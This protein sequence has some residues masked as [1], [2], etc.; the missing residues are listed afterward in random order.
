MMHNSNEPTSEN[1]W[2]WGSMSPSCDGGLEHMSNQFTF[3]GFPDECHKFEQ[4]HPIWNEI[5]GNLVKAMNLAFVRVEVM[6]GSAD[7][8][9]YFF[10][11]I[12]VED[13][14]EITLVCYH[15]YGV[16]ASKLV[17]S[18]YEYAVTLRYLNEH[19]D[20]ADT[21][22]EYHLIQQEKLIGRLIETFGENILPGE[23]IAEAKREAAE[24]KQDFMVPVCEHPGAK[25]RLNHSWNKL[26]FVAMAKK[27][28]HLG[29]LIVPGYY[30]PLRHAHPT[31]GG[32]SER[33]ELIEGHMNLR[34][35][36]QPEIVDRSL[37]TAH[38]CILDALLV[39]NQHFK[40]AELEYAM[41][42]CC[43]DFLR[44]WSPDSPILRA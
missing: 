20:E 2:L 13:F 38:N 10:G 28:G 7:K 19:P 36:A 44:V 23:Q 8:L 31:F 9:V 37:M 3:Y 25:L 16:A 43:Q 26:D 29:K 11:R 40:I 17:R 6:E 12:V 15:G 41:K 1:Q 33:L 27:T 42:V 5:M 4:R 14:L 21:F 32:L 34:A 18:M 24:V 39:Q 30:M 22:L 35:E